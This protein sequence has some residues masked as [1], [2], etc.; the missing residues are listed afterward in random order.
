MLVA[1]TGAVFLRDMPSAGNDTQLEIIAA[2]AG[3]LLGV[4]AASLVRITRNTDGRLVAAAGAG[5]AA[6]WIAV[7]VGRMVFAYSADHW[8]GASIARFSVTHQ[9][10]GAAAWTAPFVL[11]APTMILS[12]VAV[13][14]VV[15]ARSRRLTVPA[16]SAVTV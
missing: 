13:T 8:F 2:A 12:R 11:M 10:T 5:F 16:M 14:A 15:A 6:L 4:V 7:I 1:I 9:I 3:A